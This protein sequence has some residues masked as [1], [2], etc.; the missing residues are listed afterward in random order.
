MKS[1]DH[2]EQ[3][4]LFKDPY[5]LSFRNGCYEMCYCVN[6]NQGNYGSEGL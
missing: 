2:L 1:R 5:K 6:K 3:N 4:A